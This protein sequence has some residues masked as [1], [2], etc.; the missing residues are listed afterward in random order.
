[1]K[2]NSRIYVAG[3]GGLVGSAIWENLKAKEYTCLVG[4]RQRELDLT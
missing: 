2:K 3:H 4:R 1:M